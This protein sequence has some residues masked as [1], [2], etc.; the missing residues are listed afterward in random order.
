VGEGDEL[1]ERFYLLVTNFPPEAPG[2][3]DFGIQK[4]DFQAALAAIRPFHCAAGLRAFYRLYAQRYGK[5][6]WGEKTPGNGL[7]LTSITALLP[8]AHCIHLIRDGRDVALSWRQCWF[9]PGQEIE[10][11]ARE[12]CRWVSTARKQGRQCQHYLEVRYEDLI[13]QSAAVLRK[14]CEWLELPFEAGMLSYHTHS[15]LR[16]AEHGERRRLDGSLIISQADRLRQQ[17]LTMHPPDSTRI[18]SWKSAMSPAERARFAA[19]AGNLLAEL[20]YA[21]A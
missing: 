6:R 9:A 5:P 19:V 10:T 1:R 21:I 17:A 14:L 11:L 18:D 20:G 12:W 2:W 13:R 4:R 8:E 3:S 7:S 16:L 15:A